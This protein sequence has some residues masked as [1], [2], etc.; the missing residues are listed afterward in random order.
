MTQNPVRGTWLK[1]WTEVIDDFI[2]LGVLTSRDNG[3]I[4]TSEGE[5][6]LIWV[7]V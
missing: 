5:R 6:R 1:P 7:E 3:A 2:V 4:P